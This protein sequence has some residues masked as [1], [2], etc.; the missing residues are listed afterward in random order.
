MNYDSKVVILF[1]LAV[2]C[3]RS[4]QSSSNLSFTKRVHFNSV[5]SHKVRVFSTYMYFSGYKTPLQRETLI[6]FQHYS[7]ESA[8]NCIAQHFAIQFHPLF[9]Y[10]NVAPFI[11]QFCLKILHVLC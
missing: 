6:F 8:L 7:L 11:L 1:C 10:V 4:K 2:L 5:F 9:K 3:G